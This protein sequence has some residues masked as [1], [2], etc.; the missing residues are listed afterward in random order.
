M[1]ILIAGCG[2][3]GHTLAEQL[4]KEGHEVTVVDNNPSAIDAVTKDTDV[5]GYCGDCTNLKTQLEAGIKNMDLLIA[6]TNQDEKNMICCLV[7][8]KAGNCMTIARVRNPEYAS[9]MEF[10]KDELGLSMS[11]NPENAA[12]DEMARL[13]RIPSALEVDTF[14][15]GKMNLVSLFIPKESV[16]NGLRL[17]DFHSVV[18]N[19]ALI[20][21][22]KR[23]ND[24][25]IPNGDFVLQEKDKC[26]IAI[27]LPRADI[28]LNKIGIRAKRIRNVLIAGG[29]TTGYYLAKKLLDTGVNV[30]IIEINKARCEEL[31]DLLPK[32][33]V[34]E[35]DATDKTLLGEESIEEM[36][37]VCSLMGHDEENIL[38][39]LFATKMGHAKV[40]TGIH[41]NSYDDMVNELPIGQIISAKN[42]T[43][44]YI[45][46]FVR[47]M[48]NSIGSDNVEALYR[49]E[50]GMAEALEL[51]VREGSP[52]TK[53]PLKNLKIRPNTL[54]TCINHEGQ[55]RIPGGN[56]VIMAGDSIVV[57][58][59]QKMIKNVEEILEA[60]R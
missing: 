22:V 40:L 37:A 2:R 59:T 38:L 53:Q 29:S 49:L 7:A 16:L 21:M 42:I 33:L 39:S 12:A 36:D 26:S 1:N 51:N 28:F 24:V 15:K 14:A 8:K 3:V 17:R 56:D 23:G 50:D 6:V 46:R 32:A 11:I 45:I 57:V 34:I 30:K 44:E 47:S 13:I 25:I 55:A 48:Q 54:V 41:R 20:C 9:E 43:A 5:I 19:G 31:A 10:L 35:G 60:E 27:S 58:T 18:G 52:V 4:N